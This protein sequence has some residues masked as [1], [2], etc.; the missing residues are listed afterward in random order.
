MA[1][2]FTEAT[3]LKVRRSHFMY[4]SVEH[5]FMIADVG[6]L[7]IGEDA[8]LECK[9]VPTMPINGKTEIF[10]CTMSCN[11]IIIWR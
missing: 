1:E 6:R 4:R 11:A 3:G 8:G 10:R 2:R 9:R 5:P 7:I